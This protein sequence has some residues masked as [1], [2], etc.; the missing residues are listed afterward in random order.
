MLRENSTLLNVNKIWFFLVLLH[1]LGSVWIT[2]LEGIPFGMAICAS[3]IW[4]FL[5]NALKK[6]KIQRMLCVGA[7]GLTL[8]VF[9]FLNV[10]SQGT[11]LLNEC[12]FAGEVWLCHAD[13]I[14]LIKYCSIRKI[15]PL[16][17]PLILVISV[18]LFCTS[19]FVNACS[20]LFFQNCVEGSIQSSTD[21]PIFALVNTAVIPAVV[22]EIFFRGFL[23]RGIDNKKKA[24][25]ISAILFA[26]LHMNFNQMSYALLMGIFFGITIYVTDNLTI[27]ILIHLLFNAITVGKE[28]FFQ[29]AILKRILGWKIAGYAPLDPVVIDGTGHVMKSVLLSGGIIAIIAFLL[30]VWLL[31]CMGKLQ[32]NRAKDQPRI[33]E[34]VLKKWKPDIK[35]LIGC[36]LCFLTAVLTEILL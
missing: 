2:I 19:G 21:Y 9:Y 26:L 25:L 22:E 35:V 4:I 3:A 8:L 31:S 29:T 7:W 11:L 10:S 15:S 23:Y 34:V 30:S 28:Y 27:S 14:S 13:H 33:Q 16:V 17:F 12:I 36:G 20:L 5:G 24:V 18:L 6:D 32:P 1:V